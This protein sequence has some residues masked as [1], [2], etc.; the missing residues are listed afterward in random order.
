MIRCQAENGLTFKPAPVFRHE[1]PLF[2]RRTPFSPE[3]AQRPVEL[4][5]IAG[6]I[7][8]P[9]IDVEGEFWRVAN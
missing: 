8:D 5:E 7:F 1:S 6:S 4:I 3:R 9:N 2:L